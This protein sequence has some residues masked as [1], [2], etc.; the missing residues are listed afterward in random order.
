MIYQ[1]SSGS[2]AFRTAAPGFGHIC[3]SDTCQDGSQAFATLESVPEDGLF[4]KLAEC[5][6]EKAEEASAQNIAM[7]VWGFGRLA[8]H[9]AH[10]ALPLPTMVGPVQLIGLIEQTRIKQG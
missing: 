7:S 5:L 10:V 4:Q 6:Q 3:C 2:A 9:G 8:E 1:R